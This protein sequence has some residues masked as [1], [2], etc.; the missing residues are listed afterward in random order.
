MNTSF[1]QFS[2]R[3]D[4]KG[5]FNRIVSLYKKKIKLLSA[6][7]LL[8]FGIYLLVYQVFQIAYFQEEDVAFVLNKVFIVLF[9][10]TLTLLNLEVI[11]ALD[12]LYTSEALR[13]V[14]RFGL[15]LIFVLALVYFNAIDYLLEAFIISFL[16]LSAY[17]TFLIV[18]KMR[19]LKTVKDAYN[20]SYKE[21][22]K[23]SFP[24]SFSLI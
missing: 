12:L 1:L 10:F 2:G 9:P 14:G 5:E 20:I 3:L 17:S 16:L 18:F 21:I 19:R 6:M 7:F 13:N 11:R 15:L 23:V 4:A 22:L 8:F 24:M